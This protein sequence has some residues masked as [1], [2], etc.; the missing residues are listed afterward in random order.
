MDDTFRGTSKQAAATAATAPSSFLDFLSNT[1][2]FRLQCLLV[3]AAAGVASIMLGPDNYWDL[4]YY[5][6]Y[7]PWAYLHGRYLYDLG[8]AQEQG[9]LNPVAD[10]LLYGL[11]SSPLND[12]PRI[13]AF[14]MGAVHGINAALVY[15]IACHVIRVPQET[16]RWT[17]RAVAFLI[18]VTGAGWISL[19][20]GSSNDLTSALFVL[21]SFWVL[22]KLADRPAGAGAW[23]RFALAGAWIGLGVGL[24]YTSAIYAPG[25]GAVLALV[26]LRQRTFAGLIAFGLAAAAG[27]FAVTA[28]HMLTL[29]NDFRNPFFPYLNQIFHSP[30]WEPI[31]IRDDRFIPHTLWDL[32]ALPFYWVKVHTY[33]V[34]E[35]PFR[36][37]RAAA[38]YIALI[39]AVVAFAARRLRGGPAVGAARTRGFALV[40]V[41]VVVSYFAWALGFAYY[42]YAVPLEMLS[43]VIVVAALIWLLDS[44]RMRL[45]IAVTVLAVITASTI[46]IDWG[47]RDYD[48]HYVR[49]EVP[50]IPP[51][52][53]VLVATW[54]PAAYFIPYA[55]PRAEYVGIENNYLTLSQNNILANEVKAAMRAP[56][57]PKIVLNVNELD[58]AKWNKL[59]AQFGLELSPKPCA[60]IHSNLE[61]QKLSLCETVP[62]ASP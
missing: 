62:V 26:A 32:L 59:L 46:P 24:K 49:V 43:G 21:A 6:L 57:R 54:D 15:A 44:S 40:I 10:F 41:F 22:L 35:K 55:E 30:Y 14:I 50:P 23:R 39:V 4:R 45:P 11:V 47:R 34:V 37:W 13:V 1:W 18:G 27:F 19:L 33:V 48:G 52:A 3:C 7:D 28:H 61:D 36:D 12:F 25:V 51:N 5:H 9:F 8:P 60:P 56:G 20:G 42:R 2:S 17:L 38:A 58:R 16:E 29:W 53:V 31:A